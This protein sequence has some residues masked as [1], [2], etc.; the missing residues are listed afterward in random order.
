MQ[1]YLT[2]VRGF[3]AHIQSRMESGLQQN[4]SQLHAVQTNLSSKKCDNRKS[5]E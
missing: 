1:G 4:Y 3:P 5:C 2:Q